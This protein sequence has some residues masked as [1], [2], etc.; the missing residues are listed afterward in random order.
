MKKIINNF[1]NSIFFDQLP[2]IFQRR[3][4]KI[5][6]VNFCLTNFSN[7]PKK[8]YEFNF[9]EKYQNFIIN[10]FNTKNYVSRNSCKYLA[11]LIYK[12]KINFTFF[13]SSIGYLSQHEKV[14]KTITANRCKYILFSGIIFFSK[15]KY[16]SKTV[17]SFS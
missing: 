14:L 11:K 8:N 10:N 4:R 17:K 5:F 1:F 3:F 6:G 12:K 9:S 16:N 7:L 15:E 13:G 2:I